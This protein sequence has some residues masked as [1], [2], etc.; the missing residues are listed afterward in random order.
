MALE[1][2]R[3][4]PYDESGTTYYGYATAGTQDDE[5][6][7]SIKRKVIDGSVLKYEYPFVTGTTSADSYPAIS[8][9]SNYVQL[10]GL[11]W[12]NRTGYTYR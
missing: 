9:N 6:K 7:W 4:D 12:A 1:L 3:I 10:S 5:A 11:V 2:Q 8:L